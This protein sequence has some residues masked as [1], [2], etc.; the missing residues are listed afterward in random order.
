MNNPQIPVIPGLNSFKSCF[1]LR[2]FACVHV[3]LAT[4]PLDLLEE[5]QILHSKD[6]KQHQSRSCWDRS[7]K[8]GHDTVDGSTRKLQGCIKTL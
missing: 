5:T 3:F 8:V 7:E 1:I 4:Q 2:L 6:Q